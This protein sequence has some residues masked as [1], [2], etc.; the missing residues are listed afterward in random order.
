MFS[1]IIQAI[2]KVTSILTSRDGGIVLKVQTS[3]LTRSLRAGDSIALD[4]VCLTVT[5]KTSTHIQMDISAE[6]RNLTNIS[7]Y[8]NK[9]SVNLELPL[10]VG[11][12]IS[13]HIVQGHVDGVALVSEWKCRGKEDVRLLVKLP[14][15]LVPYCVPKGSI[16]IN[17][18]SLT[19]ARVKGR[20]V[21]TALIPYTLEH[22]NLGFLQPGDPVN[23]ETDILG[24]YVVS[25][26]KKAYHIPKK[27]R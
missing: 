5:K 12:L 18:V 13:G 10:K 19:I 20:E 23:I 16:A 21:E 27:G 2:G 25:A 26:V 11:D 7:N 1:G 4:G 9:T 17:G 3:K 15:A 24:R 22:T 6:T 14:D 8:K